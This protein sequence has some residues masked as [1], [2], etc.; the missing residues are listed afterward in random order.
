M[1]GRGA[2]SSPMTNTILPGSFLLERTE[3]WDKVNITSFSV[4][5]LRAQP[6][7]SSRRF[8]LRK[9]DF[10]RLFE[11]PVVGQ[12]CHKLLILLL[13]CKGLA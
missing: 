12:T 6:S 4:T 8:F 7:L 1:Y 3:R 13:R 2:S 10:P 5:G 9:D 11:H